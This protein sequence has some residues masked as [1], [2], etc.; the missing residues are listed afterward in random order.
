MK[1]IIILFFALLITVALFS[2]S[3]SNMPV[4]EQ[5]QNQENDSDANLNQENDS[6][7]N[8]NQ[9]NIPQISEETEQNQTTELNSSNHVDYMGTKIETNDNQSVETTP[10]TTAELRNQKVTFE[11]RVGRD[12][13]GNSLEDKDGTEGYV[14]NLV[15]NE[16]GN[17]YIEYAINSYKYYVFVECEESLDGVSPKIQQYQSR[18]SRE[19]E[20]IAD[21]FMLSESS[22]MLLFP[23]FK[24]YQNYQDELLNALSEDESVV[25]IKVGYTNEQNGEFEAEYSYEQVELANIILEGKNVYFESYEEFAETIYRYSRFESNEELREA[26]TEATFEYNY[27]F[28]IPNYNGIAAPVEDAVLVGNKLYLTGYRFYSNDVIDMEDT[29]SLSIVI[30]PKNELGELPQKTDL[31]IMVFKADVYVK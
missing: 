21:S 9:E 26:L 3:N 29:S 16:N 27:V 31:E 18:A 1:K 20:V 25:S 14:G 8:L 15:V 13:C 6:Y 2:C 12:A 4:E 30:I 22:A 28:A 17:E 7:A 11:L 19:L 24:S 10:L 23:D 5:G